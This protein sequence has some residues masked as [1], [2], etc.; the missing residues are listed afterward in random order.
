MNRKN[1]TVFYLEDSIL[2]YL[3]KPYIH[4]YGDT[5]TGI[6]VEI[7]TINGDPPS[8]YNIVFQ[9]F[10]FA[11]D[12][13]IIIADESASATIGANVNMIIG[14]RLYAQGSYGIKINGEASNTLLGVTCANLEGDATAL[15]FG[16]RLNNIDIGARD[17]VIVNFVDVDHEAGAGY[18]IELVAYTRRNTFFGGSVG[19]GR[20][21][22]GCGDPDPY[23][24]NRFYHV[25]GYVTEN[26]G[27]ATI[28]SGSSSVTV[29]HEM[30]VAPN[31]VK[32]TGTHSEVRDCWVT[33]IT[34]TQ[35]TIN[36]PAAVTAD[37]DVIWDAAFRLR[38]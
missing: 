5:R 18:S 34:D 15:Y 3:H 1:G 13:G 32:L 19:A 12:T 31:V 23:D 7:I 33:N 38:P 36:A 14:G 28:P 6:G 27:V 21:S 4:Q 16:S 30:S 25:Q 26:C 37:R 22:D 29:N 10:I 9:P 8:M 17:N 20:V 11:T 24:R 2:C 35:F